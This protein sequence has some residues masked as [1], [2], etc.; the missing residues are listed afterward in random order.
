MYAMMGTHTRMWR[1][2]KALVAS[3][4]G[5]G[6]C[7]WEGEMLLAA[8][9]A[10]LP[11]HRF[12]GARCVE[13]GCGPGLAGMV[14]AKMGAK[15][16]CHQITDHARVL[17]GTGMHALGVRALSN[18]QGFGWH[19]CCHAGTHVQVLLTDKACVLPLIHENVEANGLAQPCV[20]GSGRCVRP[21]GLRCSQRAHALPMLV[22]ECGYKSCCYAGGGS[23]RG[24]W[25]CRN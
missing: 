20:G 16:R 1:Q 22:H 15:V 12:I 10:S 7:V 8:Y 14:L 9:L 23:R 13:L 11:R 4:M 5:V 3:R 17:S 2:P 24:V 18:R 21:M 6:A 25:R 19:C